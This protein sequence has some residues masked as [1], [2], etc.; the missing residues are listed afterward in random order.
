MALADIK[1]IINHQITTVKGK[2]N[3]SGFHL[4]RVLNELADFADS[5]GGDGN[6]IYGGSGSLSVA[7]IVA[8]GAND[9]TFAGNQRII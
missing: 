6:G 4:N 7:T 9:L 5:G 3:I 2:T 1:K 8:M